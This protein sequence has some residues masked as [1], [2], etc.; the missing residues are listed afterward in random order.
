MPNCERALESFASQRPSTPNILNRGFHSRTSPLGRF[1]PAGIFLALLSL[2]S[3]LIF[4]KGNFTL[5]ASIVDAAEKKYGEK[6]RER[7]LAWQ[8]FIRDDDSTTELQ[9]LEKVNIFLNK[10]KFISDIV[11]WREN[12]YWATPV[13]FLASDGGDCE[14]FALAKYFTLRL[15]GVAEEKMNLTYVKAWKINQAHMVIT[16]YASPNSVPLVLDNLV[17]TIEPATN[18][19]DLLPVYSFNGSGLWIA[20][21]RGRGKFVGKSDNLKLWNDLLDRMPAGLIT[22]TK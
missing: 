14:D 10:I 13:E 8:Q 20:K 16:Y 22:N 6:A 11:H 5:D 18:R 12:D 3:L 9:K 4:A 17:Q 15:L 21:E 19:T 1:I 2:A 7:L